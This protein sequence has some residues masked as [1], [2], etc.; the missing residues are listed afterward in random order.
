MRIQ[1]KDFSRWLYEKKQQENLKMQ[2][3]YWN[4]EFTGDIP[5]LQIPTDYPRPEI[6]QFEGKSVLFGLPPDT[7][8][9]LKDIIAQE[10]CTMFMLILSLYGVLLSKLSNQEDI[11][12]GTPVSGR[13]HADLEKIIGMFVNTLPLKLSLEPGQSFLTFLSQVKSNTLKALENQD[14][15]FGELVDHI[16]STRSRDI[17]R[18]PLFDV[19]FSFIGQTE[20]TFTSNDNIPVENEYDDTIRTSPESR[21]AKFDLILGASVIGE[22]VSFSIVYGTHLYKEETITRFAGYFKEI[23]KTIS[24]NPSIKL[25]DI[26]VQIDFSSLKSDISQEINEDFAF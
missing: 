5:V 19:L 24:G 16:Y 2:A 23:V 10:N 18:N 26:R 14:Y 3:L 15:P 1:Y 8:Q 6:Q 17:Q 20:N 25:G 21:S 4:N 9:K 12:I 11:I 13:R 7:I 22:H